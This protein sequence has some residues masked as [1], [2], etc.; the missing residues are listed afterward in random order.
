MNYSQRILRLP[1]V[2]DMV[3][4]GKSAIYER[5]QTGDFPPPVKLGRGRASGWVESELQD[6]IKSQAHGRKSE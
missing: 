2:K 5:I 6:W 4:L 1:Q 3:G